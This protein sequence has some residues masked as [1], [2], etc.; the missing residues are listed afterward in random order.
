MKG[1]VGH[2]VVDVDVLA[3]ADCGIFPEIVVIEHVLEPDEPTFDRSALRFIDAVAVRI[4]EV[5]KAIALNRNVVTT[6]GDVRWRFGAAIRPWRV[7]ELRARSAVL[8]RP[9][10]F[11]NRVHAIEIQQPSAAGAI[12]AELGK[13]EPITATRHFFQQR[14]NAPAICQCKIPTVLVDEHVHPAEP[15]GVTAGQLAEL[16]HEGVVHQC[17]VLV[18][19]GIRK[20]QHPVGMLGKIERRYFA[21]LIAVVLPCFDAVALLPPGGGEGAASADADARLHLWRI[22]YCRLT[23]SV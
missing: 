4:I 23:I 6:A 18:L 12:F 1:E 14:V 22:H 19:I 8:G 7:E 21:F 15:A 3:I 2:E 16:I 13:V 5:E 11:R 10:V 17:G 9:A 20:V